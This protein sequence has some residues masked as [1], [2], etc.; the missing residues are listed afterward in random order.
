MMIDGGE[1]EKQA[2]LSVK[3]VARFCDVGI[4]MFSLVVG[5]PCGR[6]T[7]SGLRAYPPST[8]VVNVIYDECFTEPAPGGNACSVLLRV[9]NKQ[10]SAIPSALLLVDKKRYRVSDKYG[11]ILLMIHYGDS[12]RGEVQMEGYEDKS[13]DL[14]CRSDRAYFNQIVELSPVVH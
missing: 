5:E 1:A 11:R 9:R 4:E 8:R 7:V 2:A 6:V 12:L 3:G 14:R 10:G 13:L